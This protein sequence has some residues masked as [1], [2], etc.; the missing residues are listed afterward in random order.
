VR[1][2]PKRMLDKSDKPSKRW[3]AWNG[4]KNWKETPSKLPA[5]LQQGMQ[6]HI[7]SVFAHKKAAVG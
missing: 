6:D 4:R 7:D 3:V 2:K 1:I 5:D